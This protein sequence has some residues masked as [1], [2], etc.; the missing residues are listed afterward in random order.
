M[1]GIYVTLRMLDPIQRFKHTFYIQPRRHLQSDEKHIGST[2]YVG[3]NNVKHNNKTALQ[4]KGKVVELTCIFTGNK[5]F[6]FFTFERGE[7][8]RLKAS[9][10]LLSTCKVSLR[11]D[12][13]EN[14][15]L[16]SPISDLLGVSGIIRIESL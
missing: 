16:W 15:M 6:E 9:L 8:G 3:P 1:I 5:D 12:G 14:T 2:L 4:V 11:M 13:G 7:L 10:S